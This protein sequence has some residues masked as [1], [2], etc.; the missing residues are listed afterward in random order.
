MMTD[1]DLPRARNRRELIAKE[2]EGLSRD[3]VQVL[4]FDWSDD[5][6]DYIGQSSL[7]CSPKMYTIS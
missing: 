1:Q 5:M 3:D 2:H 4:Y 6:G 7:N